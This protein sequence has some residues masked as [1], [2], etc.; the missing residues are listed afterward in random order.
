M[1]QVG[2]AVAQKAMGAAQQQGE[3]MVSLLQDA[4]EQQQ[5]LQRHAN[6]PEEAGKGGKLDVRG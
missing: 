2:V 5:Q 3:A 6:G 4:A 1:A